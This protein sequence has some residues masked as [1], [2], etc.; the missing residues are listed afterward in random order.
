MKH[1]SVKLDGKEIPLIGI[2]FDATQ[3]RCVRCEKY[4]H[5]QDILLDENTNPVCLSCTIKAAVAKMFPP[6]S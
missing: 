3:E 4:W 1:A 6:S 2:D 5:L